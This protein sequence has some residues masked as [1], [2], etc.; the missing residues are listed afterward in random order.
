MWLEKLLQED[1][2]D[3]PR[4]DQSRCGNPGVHLVFTRWSA[5]ASV[6]EIEVSFGENDRAHR[7]NHDPIT[8][9]EYGPSTKGDKSSPDL[10]L[11]TRIFLEHVGEVIY[12]NVASLVVAC[13][14]Y[15]FNL[16]AASIAVSLFIK[17]GVKQMAK[18]L[19]LGMTIVILL[20]T[21]W[22]LIDRAGLYLTQINRILM[23]PLSGGLRAQAIAANQATTSYG[24]VD[25][26]P[27]TI[28]LLIGDGIVAWRAWAIY[29]HNIFVRCSLVLL[30]FANAGV[31]IADVIKEDV[32][33]SGQTHSLPLDTASVWMS[34]GVNVLATSLVAVKMI[35]H[36]IMVKGLKSSYKRKRTSVEKL[37][38]FLVESGSFFCGLQVLYPLSVIIMVNLDRSVIEESVDRPHIAATQTKFSEMRFAEGPVAVTTTTTDRTSDTGNWEMEERQ[39]SGGS[40]GSRTL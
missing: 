13:I 29:P 28:N 17:N 35:Q 18:R 19:L 11:A 15:G 30:M 8:L 9:A 16:L 3:R 2:G 32:D 4:N 33:P 1:A 37:F 25:G 14:A 21:T 7:L 31:N 12:W 26:W 23:R 6:G 5:Q 20:S 27:V 34:L 22:D 40:D 39:N 36:R 24:Y 38:L 10:L